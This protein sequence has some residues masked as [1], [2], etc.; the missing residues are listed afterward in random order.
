MMSLP[1]WT[2]GP[3]ELLVH[4]ES[5]LCGGD[6]S[7]RRIALISFDNGVEVAI[8]TYLTLKPIQRAN[9]THAK[10]DLEWWRATTTRSSTSWIQS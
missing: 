4:T 3:F 9:K 2:S 5:Y 1:P 8:T 7:D 6:D 10:V